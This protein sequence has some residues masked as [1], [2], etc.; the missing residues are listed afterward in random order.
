[1]VVLHGTPLDHRYTQASLEPVFD[2]RPGWK[3]YYLDLPGH[4]QSPAPEAIQNNADMV[5]VLASWIDSTLPGSRFALVGL[6]YGGY[7]ARALARRFSHRVDGLFLWVPASY[8]RRER[9]L[10]ERAVLATDAE[11][12][13]QLTS[14]NERHFFE[15]LTVQSPAALA[16]IR[17]VAVPAG[18]VVNEAFLAR[19]TDTKLPYDPDPTEFRKPV[20]IVCGRQDSV[21]GY[22]EQTEFADRYP[23]AT[24]AVL[25]TGGHFTGAAEEVGLFRELVRDWLA[26][27]T[28]A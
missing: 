3:R 28:S 22:A 1:M 24:L 8:P 13:A 12:A 18:E 23:R 25:D 14:E 9:R 7:L 27:M 4:G 26:R 16:T 19:V 10:P 20:L 17:E 5:D 15:L 11:A 21:V 6:S 2:G